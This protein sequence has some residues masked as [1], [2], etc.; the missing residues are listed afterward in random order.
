MTDKTIK[1]IPYG[2]ANYERV[3]QNNCYYV[4]KTMYLKTVE[5]SGDYLFFIR[6]RRFGKSLF[7]SVMQAYYDVHYK[8]RF[9][10]LFKGTW[11]YDHPTAERGTYLVLK[12]N[13]SVIDPKLEKFEE[14]FLL[15]LKEQGN[16]FLSRYKTLLDVDYKPALEEIRKMNSSSDILRRLINLCNMSSR[17]VYVIIDEYDNFANT[18]LSTTGPD[19]YEKLTHGTGSF[20]SFFNVLKGG[21][22]DTG[23]P[24]TRSF[25]TGVSPV[26]MDDVTS[27]Y[28][29]GKNVSLEPDLNRML[30]FTEDDV[31]EMVEYYRSKGLVNHS[32]D[33][34]LGIMTEWYGNYLFSEYD[35]VRLFNSDM[36]L[37]FF[38]NYLTRKKLP[39]D[40]IDRNVRMDYGKLRHLITVDK[41]GKK[42]SNGNFER[43]REIIKEGKTLSGLVKGFP[44]EK[45]TNRE[46]FI[47]LLFYFGLLTVKGTEAAALALEIPNETIRRLYYD[48][49][50]EA[51]EETDIFALDLY[52]YNRLMRGMAMEGEWKPLLDYITGR[53]RE[54][55]S[56]RD[57]IAG[58]K[59]I[60]AFLNVYL[61][62]STLYIIHTEKELNKGYADIVMEP[63]T[64]RYESLNYSYIL[65]I[66]YIKAEVKPGDPKVR[67]LKSEAEEQ[68]RVYS[69]DEKYGKVIE[70]TTLVKLVLI[71]SGHEAVY[72]GDVK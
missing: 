8:D 32:T 5:E 70:K 6:P 17:Q 10:E 43:L 51:Y 37:Y 63:F 36:I 7:L 68:L 26:T 39:D 71:F 19:D 62:L 20:R 38:D 56:L 28:N 64:A 21:T 4:D 22:T 3:V 11:I 67:R 58:E 1:R 33:Y 45:L 29:I 60:Q 9:E 46:N 34:L 44:L 13:F 25:V 15:Y 52:T 49:I 24:I 23:A 30:G 42:V 16:A 14:S 31:V 54:S 61:G 50:K 27:G 41:G 69:I 2:L 53:M 47:S 35:D 48:Y 65:E 12:F 40:L 55:I 66:K 57:L 18:I 72:I 59:S